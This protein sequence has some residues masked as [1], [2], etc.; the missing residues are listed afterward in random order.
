MCVL[1]IFMYVCV[2]VCTLYVCIVCI[3]EYGVCVCVRACVRAWRTR[4]HE[5]SIWLFP[6][7]CVCVDMYI[8][9]ML[10]RSVYMRMCTYQC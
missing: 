9:C 10:I 2:S 4:V 6:F 1:Y 5:S 7:V 8:L 3:Y